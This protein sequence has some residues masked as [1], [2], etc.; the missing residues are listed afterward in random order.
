MSFIV[1]D[2]SQNSE[3]LYQVRDH[4]YGFE[5]EE[6]FHQMFEEISSEVP[7]FEHEHLERIISEFSPDFIEDLFK[8]KPCV[9]NLRYL[10]DGFDE[11][12]IV[13]KIYKSISF[14]GAHYVFYVNE[15]ETTGLGSAYF[16]WVDVAKPLF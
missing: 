7:C 4:S 14:N 12:L 3:I 2:A 8:H 11:K 15:N 10:G 5:K 1:P 6:I 9:R 16:E 13:G